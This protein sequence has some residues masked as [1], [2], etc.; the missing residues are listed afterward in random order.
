MTV[1]CITNI[2]IAFLLHGFTHMRAPIVHISL[3]HGLL[4]VEYSCITVTCIFPEYGTWSF[5]ISLYWYETLVTWTCYI[6]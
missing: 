6:L 3:L 4:L 2:D 5:S 1:S